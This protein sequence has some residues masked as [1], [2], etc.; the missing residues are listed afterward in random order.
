MRYGM[1][2]ASMEV[3]VRGRGRGHARGRVHRAFCRGHARWRC[4]A[5]DPVPQRAFAVPEALIFSQGCLSL[6]CVPP[7]SI[8][9]HQQDV[10]NCANEFRDCVQMILATH[11]INIVNT[12]STAVAKLQCEN[13]KECGMGRDTQPC[14]CRA[15]AC[16]PRQHLLKRQ[17][18]QPRHPLAKCEGG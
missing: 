10:S 13:N 5:R 3:S 9:A 14:A 2:S 4:R 17:T 18:H 1:S 11:M 15:G 6:R 8:P 7:P 16:A 12:L